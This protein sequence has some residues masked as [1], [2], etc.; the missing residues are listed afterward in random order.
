MTLWCKRLDFYTVP[1]FFF[2]C[3]A[4]LYYFFLLRKRKI[5]LRP[6]MGEKLHPGAL[7]CTPPEGVKGAVNATLRA[8]VRHS[9]CVE[10]PA[11]ALASEAPWASTMMILQS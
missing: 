8:G 2:A 7:L 11:G 3:G 10:G 4:I 9:A 1:Q 5:E 6:D